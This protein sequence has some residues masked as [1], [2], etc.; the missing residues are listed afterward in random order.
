MANKGQ[1]IQ[2]L[3]W[4]NVIGT[5]IQVSK[6]YPTT[7]EIIGELIQ[8]SLRELLDC[9]DSHFDEITPKICIRIDAKAK[10]IQV[11]DNGRG[12]DAIRRLGLANTRH[13]GVT[14]SGFGVG[15]SAVI[16]NSDHCIIST[17]IDNKKNEIQFKKL[18]KRLIEAEKKYKTD[19]DKQSKHIEEGCTWKMEKSDYLGTSVLFKSDEVL[20]DLWS[21]IDKHSFED[22]VSLLY[23]RTPLGFTESIW[24]DQHNIEDLQRL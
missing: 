13:E 9:D 22:F 18:K 6:Q 16:A 20:S 11:V 4:S 24:K 7:V 14:S 1:Q 17:S 10:S 23:F 2:L 21:F 3:K 5:W 12:F 15:L 19:T 8:N